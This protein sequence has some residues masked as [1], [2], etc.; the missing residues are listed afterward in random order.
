MRLEPDPLDPVRTRLEAA[1]VNAEAADVMLLGP[2]L[3]VR[4]PEV[5]VPPSKLRH[6][7]RLVAQSL[8]H[9]SRLFTDR[10]IWL[11]VANHTLGF[12]WM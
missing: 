6:G 1:D 11:P 3:C 10:A 7:G 5:V 8:S 2:R 12:D 4:N 9:Y